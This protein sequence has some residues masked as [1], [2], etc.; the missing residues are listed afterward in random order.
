MRYQSIYVLLFIVAF[1]VTII[2]IPWVKEIGVQYK[3]LDFPDNRKNK[4]H[5]PKVRIGGVA[6]FISYLSGIFLLLISSYFNKSIILDKNF[7]FLIIV[8]STGFFGIG[9]ADDIYSLPP[10]RRLF[11]QYILAAFISIKGFKSVRHFLS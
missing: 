6:F 7:L 4:Y 2:V 10:I 8:I 11:L 3:L 1:L 5:I 9:F